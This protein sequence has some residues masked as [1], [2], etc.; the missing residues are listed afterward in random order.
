MHKLI[1]PSPCRRPALPPGAANQLAARSLEAHVKR[2]D[3]RCL[4]KI[5]R[6]LRQVFEQS[7]PFFDRANGGPERLFDGIGQLS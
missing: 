6:I 2:A 4:L 3:D 1:T 5:A 7:D